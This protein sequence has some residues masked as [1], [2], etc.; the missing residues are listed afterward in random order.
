M[1]LAPGQGQQ[2]LLDSHQLLLRRR[3]QV[4]ALLRQQQQ[5]LLDGLQQQLVLRWQP[6]RLL[7]RPQQLRL[8][9]LHHRL[10]LLLGCHRRRRLLLLLG[11][12][13]RR[14]LSAP[15]PL[16]GAVLRVLCLQLGRILRGLRRDRLAPGLVLPWLLRLRGLSQLTAML[17]LLLRRFE[18][19][20]LAALR[21][22]CSRL[23]LLLQAHKLA[24]RLCAPL[25]PRLNLICLNV[26]FLLLLLLLPLL[27]LLP[28]LRKLL[29]PLGLRLLHLLPLAQ[30]GGLKLLP[31]LLLLL[32][33][34][35]GLPAAGDIPRD[36]TPERQLDDAICAARAAG[37]GGGAMDCVA[38]QAAVGAVGVLH[39][40]RQQGGHPLVLAMLA[41]RLRSRRRSR[42]PR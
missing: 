21:L 13:P 40:G 34:Q 15:L 7:Q 32:P 10:L 39:G 14:L 3:R 26:S 33:A 18:P 30:Q 27:P 19:R 23:Q 36:S 17:L 22:G 37:R 42:L 12:R 2:L 20:L 1:P 8:Q 5:L 16:P 29:L 4:L 11:Q 31:L 35:Q 24:R 38:A 6:L 25:L 9:R 41:R 28:L